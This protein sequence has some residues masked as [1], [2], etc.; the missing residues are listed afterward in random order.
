MRKHLLVLLMALTSVVAFAQKGTLTG[1]ITDKDLN[2]E[3]L[4][5]ANV[6]VKGTTNAVTTDE[7][8]KYTFAL[9]AGTYVI[10][11]SFLGYE[12]QTE[13]VTIVSGETVTV[14]K[15][16]GAGSYTLQDVKVQAQVN[17]QKESSLL[18]EQKN[19]VEIKQNIGAQ[20]LSRKGVTDVAAAVVKTT[21]V[22]KQEGSG[23]I[24]V[25]G[26]GDRYNASTMNGLPI[27]SNDAE[28]K[29]IVLDIFPTEIVEYVSID[30]VYGSKLYGDFAGGNVDIVSKEHRGKGTFRI[31]IGSNANTNAVSEN[32]FR[33]HASPNASGFGM[34]KK[35]SNS[36]TQYNYETLGMD[37]KSPF[38]GSIG[39]SGGQSW[40]VGESGKLS[41]FATGSFSN[42]YQS[43]TDGQANGSISPTGVINKRYDSFDSFNYATNTTGMANIAYK[44]NANHKIKFNSLFINTSDQQTDEYRGYIVDLANDGNGFVRINTFTKTSL[45][46]NQL[47]GEHKFTDRLQL[48]WSGAFNNVNDDQPDRTWNTFNEQA[49]GFTINSQ[50]APNNNRYFQELTEKEYNANISVDY[51]IFKNGDSDY[52]GKLTLGYNGRM[53]ERDFAATQYNFKATNTHLGDI[54]DPDNLDAF[55][56][57][58]NLTNGF[59]EISTFRGSAQ[60]PGATRPQTYNGD[61]DVHAAF[62]SIEY[63]F[64]PNLT[65]V[66]GLR[67]EMIKQNMEWDTSLSPT[68]QNE[69][70][71]T[72]ILPSLIVKYSLNDKQNLRFAFSKTY[73]LPQFKERAPFAYERATQVY[74]GNPNLYESDN[75]NLDLKW[76]MFP[77]SDEVFS[78]TAFGKYI[79]N[80]INEAVVNSS[81]N[82]ISYLNS[83]DYGYA[84]GIEIEVRKNIFKTEETNS[85]RLSAGLNVS[86]LYT[87]QELNNDKVA[88]ETNLNVDFTDSKSAFTG[89]SDWLGNADLSYFTEWNQKR[90]NITATVAYNLF[91]DRIYALGTQQRG[92]LVDKSVGTLDFIIKSK[93]NENLGIGLTARNLTNPAIKQV[94]ENPNGDVLSQTYKKGTGISLSLNYTF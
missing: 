5:F 91:S 50:S 8:G 74:F 35:P 82:D 54:V 23:N 10:E 4:P 80:P 88:A 40:N 25:R 32:N 6:L 68:G 52:N 39:I 27:P 63:T 1:T 59:F 13:N 22:T 31:D 28:K 3:P 30:K 55:Y 33:L 12:T 53:K 21:G 47:L 34:T 72:A 19:A 94:Q 29:N 46:I 38:G 70:T 49:N 56:N 57:Q 90:A 86:Y 65:A 41:L 24:F 14:D 17:R 61:L 45:F 85:K 44:I 26:L 11:Y 75:Y 51:K 20:E 64:N 76:E 81:T 62:G 69:L 43:I 58:T 73:T 78:A 83:G 66:L 71:K 18:L 60:V 93:L 48:N 16:L 87:E 92:N 2:N 89:A 79:V 9:E 84:A 77:T 67:G 42:E 37:T 7:S 36:L 15:V